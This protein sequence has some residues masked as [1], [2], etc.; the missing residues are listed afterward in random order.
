MLTI[1]EALDLFDYIQP[2]SIV[3]LLLEEYQHPHLDHPH[4]G[5]LTIHSLDPSVHAELSNELNEKTLYEATTKGYLGVGSDAK[6]KKGEK[7]GWLTGINYMIPA[8][9]H[10]M[11]DLCNYAS[12]ECAANCLGGSGRGAF[13]V[14]IQSRIRKTKDFINNRHQFLSNLHDDIKKTIKYAQKKQMPL[15]LRLNGTSDIGW[16]GQRIHEHELLPAQ[17][18]KDRIKAGGRKAN[19]NVAPRSPGGKSMM[20]HFQHETSGGHRV[21]FYDYTKNPHL[22]IQHREG[23]L[24]SNYDVT[25]SATEEPHSRAFAVDHALKGGRSA[26]VFNVR[27]AGRNRE[28]DPLPTHFHGIPVIDGDKSDLRHLDP[29]GV[30]VGLRYKEV[31]EKKQKKG[32]SRVSPFV[33][34]PEDYNDPKH[35]M[36]MSDAER[37]DVSNRAKLHLDFTAKKLQAQKRL[38]DRVGSRK[39]N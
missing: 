8:G 7:Q 21:Q 30:I 3:D 15:A 2:D 5:Y 1:T 17:K 33:V 14:V 10:K 6:T 18:Q 31:K 20:E 12:K 37:Q 22:A 11:P 29:K 16:H 32:A 34:Q 39:G 35:K 38:R 9:R 19:T 25:Y 13:K 26:V 28:A 36:P 4:I 24:P 27:T 23:K